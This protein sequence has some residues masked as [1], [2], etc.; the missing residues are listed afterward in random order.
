MT[1]DNVQAF[2]LVELIS[3]IDRELRRC[4]W[5]AALRDETLRKII[6]ALLFSADHPHWAYCY[7]YQMFGNMTLQQIAQLR[8]ISKANVKRNLE[9]KVPEEIYD[10]LPPLPRAKG[11]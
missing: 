4:D 2:A 7:F 11:E 10:L 6:A 9:L 5:P 1:V 8:N 3:E